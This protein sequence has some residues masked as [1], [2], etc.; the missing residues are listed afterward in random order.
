MTCEVAVGVVVAAWTASV[1]ESVE[2]LASDPISAATAAG[3][4]SASSSVITRRAAMPA[5]LRGDGSDDGG[6]DRARV[7]SCAAA[8]LCTTQ[9]AADNRDE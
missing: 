9:Q 1:P 6:A 8:H 2:S 7:W 5:Y 4:V 3:G